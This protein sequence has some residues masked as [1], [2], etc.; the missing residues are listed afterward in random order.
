VRLPWTDRTLDVD[1]G[2][3]PQQW[4]I[5]QVIDNVTLSTTGG[6]AW[7][8][9][10]AEAWAFLSDAR[11]LAAVQGFA[12]G[13]LPLVGRRM[14]VRGTTRPFDSHGW[15]R[16]LTHRSP[17]R[18]A[19]FDAWIEGQ[20]VQIRD[21]ATH[22]KTVY[23][24]V[25]LNGVPPSLRRVSE[26]A[27][28]RPLSRELDAL[29]RD[30]ESVRQRLVE[31]L[32]VESAS[33]AA[34]AHLIARSVRV[35]LPGAD[36]PA[37]DLDPQALCDRVRWAAHPDQRC[38]KVTAADPL[39]DAVAT[40][41]VTTVV[42]GRPPDMEV[43]DP[44]H[45]PWATLVD[46]LP[47]PTELTATV[48]LLSGPDAAK[49]AARKLKIVRDQQAAYTELELDEPHEFERQARHA[50]AAEDVMRNAADVA[51]ARAHGWFRLTVWGD[52]AEEALR[53]AGTVQHL[54][55]DRQWRVGHPHG[56]YA[57]T[58]ELMPC[59]PLS[60]TAYK[61]RLP[62]LMLAAGMPHVAAQVG[63]RVGP[64]LGTTVG[65]GRH[66]VCLDTHYATEV[67]E[68][69]GVVLL[70]GENG[71]GKSALLAVMA[72]P[73]VRRGIK[74]V[75]LD[76][77]GPMA[78]LCDLFPG[79]SSHLSLSSAPTGTL[80][81]WRLIPNPRRY[82]FEKDGRPTSEVDRLY[83]EAKALAYSQRIEAAEDAALG[84][85]PWSLAEEKSTPARLR[86]AIREVGGAPGG[87]FE[88][89]IAKLQQGDEFAQE[90]ADELNAA[91]DSPQGKLYLGK[92]DRGETSSADEDFGALLTV[93]TFPGL[94]TPDPK[95]NR[96]Y[97]QVA[98]RRAAVLMR[99]ALQF[100][101]R[102]IYTG[103]MTERKL[104]ALD[105]VRLFNEDAAARAFGTRVAFDSRKWNACVP[106]ATQIPKHHLGMGLE[107]LASTVLV[108]HLEHEDT[109][110]DACDLLHVPRGV[111]Y[112]ATFATLNPNANRRRTS[113][114]L[115][116]RDWIVRGVHN[117]IER[118]RITLPPYL[119]SAIDT[120][121]RSNGHRPLASV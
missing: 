68:R 104:V 107:A 116:Y 39:T 89:V 35:G 25:R 6:T 38:V 73:A 115:P 45:A 91:A 14:Y 61:R 22:E 4:A 52:T 30:E 75:L 12:T 7:Y 54:F 109:A 17:N 58:R 70:A 71:A 114:Q 94:Q 44:A 120:T 26:W 87:S 19:G 29:R 56:Q 9:L 99:L 59:E 11:R 48:D 119:H 8:A 100:T 53:R 81:P 92:L 5:R 10:P 57:L 20:Q 51:A 69:S 36:S 121:A 65:A 80:S 102:A 24:G 2:D 50:K 47:F 43:P 103:S 97:W 84:T 111:G 37:G 32:E 113:A 34:L 72:E 21:R 110:G 41:Y 1:E 3:V 23:L 74:T 108:G 78:G 98:E 49:E 85:L 18:I 27:L 96:K 105:E 86:K 83:E 16:N 28:R 60:T 63:D 106:L 64:V 90:L 112:E 117:D 42:L 46:Q 55:T 101:S 118:V 76:P 67:A 15:A 33:G 62:L 13:L 79:R 88:L 66:L 31:R 82:H 77:S 40:A 95:S 93:V